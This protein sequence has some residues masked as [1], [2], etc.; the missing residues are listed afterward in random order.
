[1]EA[2]FFAAIAVMWTWVKRQVS[3]ELA[4]PITFG[5]FI[6]RPRKAPPDQGG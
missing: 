4:R 1:M 2:W 5:A 3:F 6:I